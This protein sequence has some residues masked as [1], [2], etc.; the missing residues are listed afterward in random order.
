LPLGLEG[1]GE[2]ATLTATRAPP[3]LLAPEFGL[4]TP[5]AVPDPD[6]SSQLELP[7][8]HVDGSA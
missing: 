2:V 8:L 3:A 4:I 1:L 7:G 6:A 5:T